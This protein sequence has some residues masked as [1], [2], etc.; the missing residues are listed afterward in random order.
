M[1][2]TPTA[3]PERIEVGLPLLV[4]STEALSL[5]PGEAVQLRLIK[6]THPSQSN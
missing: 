3:N 2:R 4:R 5:V 1:L 6:R